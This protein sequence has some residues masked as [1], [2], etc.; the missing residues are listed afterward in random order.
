[1]SASYHASLIS[2]IHNTIMS[3]LAQDDPS[4]SL[5][6]ACTCWEERA[7]YRDLDLP[8]YPPLKWKNGAFA[9]ARAGHLALTQFLTEEYTPTRY[10]ALDASILA[11][12]NPDIF[13]WYLTV[14]EK[15]E[16]M[17]LCFVRNM[18]ISWPVF[19]RFYLVQVGTIQDFHAAFVMAPDAQWITSFIQCYYARCRI[20]QRLQVGY[21]RERVDIV[22]DYGTFADFKRVRDYEGFVF[23]EGWI[24][25]AIGA[26]KL[27]ILEYILPLSPSSALSFF[28]EHAYE[29]ISRVLFTYRAH[30]S[31][32]PD[33]Y[34]MIKYL[35]EHGVTAS[36]SWATTLIKRMVA[37]KDLDITLIT[38]L[39]ALGL[40]NA[41]C[42]IETYRLKSLPAFGLFVEQLKE[43][44]INVF[45][46]KTPPQ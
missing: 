1:M 38:K 8:S 29:F 5:M 10:E 39:L 32:N 41:E 25:S 22:I 46:V 24:T 28:V 44:F 27:D 3:Q 34:P 7:R 15:P 16:S 45:E 23:Y 21:T 18:T 17:K 19:E 9:S 40:P 14:V 43:L 26:A 20:G 33:I 6:L 42:A 37:L 11:S 35:V 2:D 36:R 30:F 13:A 4:A 12:P 31:Y